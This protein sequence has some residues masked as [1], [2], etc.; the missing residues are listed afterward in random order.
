MFTIRPYTRGD[1]EEVDRILKDVYYPEEPLTRANGLLP[2]PALA[3]AL[4]PQGHSYIATSLDGRLVGLALNDEPPQVFPTIYT[5]LRQDVKFRKMFAYMEKVSGV[6]DAAPGAME[7]RMMAVDPAWRGLG[8]A[9]ALLDAAR[10]A[11]Q[12]AGCPYI[13]I[14]CTSNHSSRLLEKLGWKLQYS[15]SYRDYLDRHPCSIL[16]PP[17]P[18][19]HCNLY[20]DTV[21]PINGR[22]DGLY[23]QHTNHINGPAE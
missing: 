23:S 21:Q 17:E 2:E 18:H 12:D 22:K 19:T 20:I 15:M 3:K 5:E 8:V 16:L 7:V 6:L 9:T 13:K 14:Y 11:A 1:E 4:L 10:L